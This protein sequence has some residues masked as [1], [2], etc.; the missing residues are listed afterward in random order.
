MEKRD[1]RLWKKNLPLLAILLCAGIIFLAVAEYHSNEE[2]RQGLSDFDEEAYTQR[3]ETRLGEMIEK[4]EGVRDVKVMIT[5]ESGSRY[6]FSREEKSLSASGDGAVGA[7]FLSDDT[8]DDPILVEIG[9]PKIKGVSVVC[10]GADNIL[11][12]EKIL[13]LIAGTLDLTQNKIYVTE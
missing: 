13:G 10:Q 6:R 2:T 9:A 11:I 7:F 8:G 1:N 12:R 4:M 5:L 3:L